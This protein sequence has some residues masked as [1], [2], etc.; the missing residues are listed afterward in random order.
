RSFWTSN[1]VVEGNLSIA[2]ELKSAAPV[3][4]VRVPGFESAANIQTLD[5]GHVRVA[6]D[7]TGARLDRDFVFYYR[8]ADNLPGRVEVIPY[9]A[10][11]KKPGTFMMVVTPGIDLKPITT[12]AD[13]A[14]VLDTSGS[15]QG[16]IHTLAQG[17]SQELV[18]EADA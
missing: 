9:R 3:A 2:L 7:R 1:S 15:M 13:F 11:P 12:G 10:D 14:F 16:K 17:V 5:A 18:T 8:L 4:D 6:L